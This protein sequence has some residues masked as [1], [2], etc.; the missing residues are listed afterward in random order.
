M[1]TPIISTVIGK[2]KYCIP[3]NDTKRDAFLYISLCCMI[4][5]ISSLQ[6]LNYDEKYLVTLEAK[7]YLLILPPVTPSLT[8]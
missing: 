2:N 7:R 5:N 3:I 6:K 4:D 1:L 8:P